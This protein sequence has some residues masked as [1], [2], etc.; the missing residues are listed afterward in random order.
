VPKIVSLSSLTRSEYDNLKKSFSC[1]NDHLDKYIKQ[2]AFAHQKQGLFQTYFLIDD[3]DIYL[4]YV[5]VAPASIEREIIE[6]EIKVPP[7]MKYSISALKITR[8]CTFDGKCG[9]GFGTVF[10][11]L[12]NLLAIIQQ[13]TIGCRAIIV[14][15]KPEAVDFYKRFDFMKVAKEDDNDTI[16][17]VYDILQPT[18][19]KNTIPLMIKFCNQYHLHEYIEI[20]DK[21]LE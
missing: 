10:I 11:T 2:F 18:E 3:S 1:K 4:G 5:S 19:L 16:F 8:L 7:S 13:I 14:D 15:S 12:V 21:Q 20:L 9:N 17:M 6:D